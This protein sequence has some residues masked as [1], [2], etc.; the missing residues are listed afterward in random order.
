MSKAVPENSRPERP[1]ATDRSPNFV[2]FAKS[3]RSYGGASGYSLA[4]DVETDV[5]ADRYE[6]GPRLGH[7]AT[8]STRRA[9]DRV[10]GRTVAVKC[11]DPKKWSSP[12]GRARFE[13][14][15]RLAASVNHPRV[16]TVFDV[17]VA[18]DVPY[19][20]MEC[21]P[22]N[23]LADDIREGPLAVA[24]ACEVLVDVLA[25]L[26]A[27]HECGVIHRDLKPANILFDDD[28][29]AKLADFGIATSGTD[30]HITA[31]GIVVGTPAYLS[32][33]RVA[34]EPATVRSD[35]YAVG[36]IAYEAL[37]GEKPFKGDDPIAVAYAVHRAQ[38]TPLRELRPEVPE[39]VAA[40]VARAMSPDPDDR[41]ATA[42][43]F[44]T[45]LVRAQE[46]PNIAA[47]VPAPA[48]A[49]PPE[50]TRTLPVQRPRAEA[51]VRAPRRRR[52]LVPLVVVALVLLL[53]VAVVVGVSRHNSAKTPASAT[54]TTVA[55]L[56][57]ALEGPF[58][59]LQQAV[60][61]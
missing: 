10:L 23:T 5:L 48:V 43:E 42:D 7:G 44:T 49:P 53:A 15:A 13:L 30:R 22:G 56:P 28:G 21:L 2:R 47:T 46:E 40:V 29:R 4:V 41:F 18:G 8:S 20:V 9:R 27:A 31:T 36:V 25:G 26:Q 50:P 33:E 11:F 3:S 54:P 12:D 60:K 32:P 55:P 57:P 59:S 39:A 34:G 58:T 14:E 24:R 51:P 61:R 38:P 16:V 45:A 1:S 19:L 35:L 37:S 17:G 52:A 6:L